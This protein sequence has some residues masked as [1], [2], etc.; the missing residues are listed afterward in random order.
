MVSFKFGKSLKEYIKMFFVLSRAWDKKRN[1][2][3]HE[4][5]NVRAPMLYH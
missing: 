2:S 1:L 5:S 4:E 3:P